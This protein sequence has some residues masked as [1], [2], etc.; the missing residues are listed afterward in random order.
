MTKTAKV[1][2]AVVVPDAAAPAPEVM[3]QTFIDITQQP[4]RSNSRA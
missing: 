4:A 3:T 1:T 2:S